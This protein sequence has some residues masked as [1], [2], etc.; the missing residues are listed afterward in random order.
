M[1]LVGDDGEL[2]QELERDDAEGVLVGGF[3]D[4]GAGSSGLLDLEPASGADTPAIAGLET[5]EAILRH[6][7][8]EIVAEALGGG[9]EVGRDDAADGV[10]AEVLFAG[11][12]ATGSVEAGHGLAAAGG[13]G[14]A[15]DV[16]CGGFLWL[17]GR[18]GDEFPPLPFQYP[19]FVSGRCVRGCGSMEGACAQVRALAADKG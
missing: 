1:E 18:H 10:D 13:E 8:D 19:T 15:E 4:D 6:G 12:A 11:L 17:D 14:L 9:E 7:G 3:K 16:L 2:D 5:G